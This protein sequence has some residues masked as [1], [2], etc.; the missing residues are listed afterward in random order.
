VKA[1]Q[2][3]L[4]LRVA[5]AAI[6]SSGWVWTAESCQGHPDE[7]DLYA[8]WGHNTQPYLRLVCR[9]QDLGDAVAALL[10]EA[11]DE[12]D[13]AIGTPE[14]RLRTRPL[15][16]GWMEL[17]VYV[18][19]HNVA[20]RNRG[21]QAFERFGFAIQRKPLSASSDEPGTLRA[22]ID[23]PFEVWFK[24]SDGSR[25]VL[26]ERNGITLQVFGFVDENE[27]RKYCEELA[28]TLNA[29]ATAPPFDALALLREARPYLES[30]AT[31]TK[32][33]TAC[34]DALELAGRIRTA[35]TKIA[36]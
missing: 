22:P 36:E 15:R 8:A 5:V 27:H 2:I 16:D 29:R 19:A 6:N 10:A 17:Q 7:S 24:P 30:F 26:D 34:R 14:M 23:G 32:H 20:T 11:G 12:D 3:D 35:L 25:G 9:A 13:K 31:L 21:C 33:P 18:S 4:L 1:E 28:N